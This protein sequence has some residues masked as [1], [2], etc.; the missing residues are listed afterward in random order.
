[1]I[2][3]QLG[4]DSMMSDPVAHLNLTTNAFEGALRGFKSLGL[5]WIALGGG[6]YDL[7]NVA[8]CWTLAW[9]VISGVELPEVLVEE[10]RSDIPIKRLR[11][12]PEVMESEVGGSTPIDGDIEELIRVNLPLVRDGR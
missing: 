9:A 1:M 11:D 5:P 6:G 2:V 10:F 4:V 8:R 3:T 7:A 12:A